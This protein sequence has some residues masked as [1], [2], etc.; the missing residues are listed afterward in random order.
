MNASFE[1]KEIFDSMLQGIKQ[2]RLHV[3]NSSKLKIKV[4]K[5]DVQDNIKCTIWVKKLNYTS[6]CTKSIMMMIN[7]K[8]SFNKFRR[9]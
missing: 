5:F 2:T 7:I 8:Y 4:H 1:R 6:K 3:G 9:N